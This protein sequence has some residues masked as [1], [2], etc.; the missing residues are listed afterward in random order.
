MMFNNHHTLITP[1]R[2]T[3]AYLTALARSLYGQAAYCRFNRC[4][5]NKP[6]GWYLYR[7]D[8]PMIAI[9]QNMDAAYA[10]LMEIVDAI[11][12]AEWLFSPQ[13]AD[14]NAKKSA[15]YVKFCSKGQVFVKTGDLTASELVSSVRH[16]C[17]LEE[18]PIIKIRSSF[19]WVI[20]GVYN[21]SG[22][23]SKVGLHTQQVKQDTQLFITK[24]AESVLSVY[25]RFDGVRQGALL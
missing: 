1:R 16:A 10:Y 3:G 2:L 18:Q 4:S 13:N 25:E 24:A 7:P 11:E 23:S 9:G 5:D 21:A 8:D 17:G 15:N 19:Y 14:A 12:S 20:C 6:V 22:Q